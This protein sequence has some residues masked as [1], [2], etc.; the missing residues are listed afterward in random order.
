MTYCVSHFCFYLKVPHI[1]FA[2]T[3]YIIIIIQQSSRDLTKWLHS[4]VVGD[5]VRDLQV[6]GFRA[7]KHQTMALWEGFEAQDESFT[8]FSTNPFDIDHTD[9]VS[10][11]RENVHVDRP[12]S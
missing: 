5:S 1:C 3:N 6:F 10:P 8:G 2:P 11:R 9:H 12:S 4:V 7:T